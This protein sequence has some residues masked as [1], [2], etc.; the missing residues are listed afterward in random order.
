MF[1]IKMTGKEDTLQ[2]IQKSAVTNLIPGDFMIC[3]VT[4]G[5]GA[6]IGMVFIA[7]KLKIQSEKKLAKSVYIVA[8]AGMTTLA[9]ADQQDASIGILQVIVVI[10]VSELSYCPDKISFL[11]VSL[12]LYSSEGRFDLFE[13]GILWVRFPPG[14]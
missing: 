13:V 6:L 11:T 1:P 2:V 7:Q 12:T 9:T 4:Y 8:V 10:Q 5:N 14:F 3:T